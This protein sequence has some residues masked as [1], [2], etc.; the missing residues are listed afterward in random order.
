MARFHQFRHLP[1]TGWATIRVDG[2][3]IFLHSADVYVMFK[4][5]RLQKPEEE[6][7]LALLSPCCHNAIKRGFE[8]VSTSEEESFP[9]HVASCQKCH[10]PVRNLSPSIRFTSSLGNTVRMQKWLTPWIENPVAASAAAIDLS[11]LAFEKDKQLQ[12]IKSN[13]E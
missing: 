2:Q 6:S 11:L 1:E 3:Y 12:T 8:L 4:A 10:Q 9:R 5:I 7:R 13:H